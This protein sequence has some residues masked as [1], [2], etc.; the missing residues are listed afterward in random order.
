MTS[1][2]IP[3][4]AVLLLACGPDGVGTDESAEDEVGEDTDTGDDEG[5]EPLYLLTEG[6]GAVWVVDV[7]QPGM[8]EAAKIVPE[9]EEV[10]ATV[11]ASPLARWAAI[12]TGSA[13]ND[14][15]SV[16]V[17]DFVGAPLAPA[18][19]IAMDFP[20]A[21]AQAWFAGDESGLAIETRDL[22][23]DSHHLVYVPLDEQ[24]AGAP[25]EAPSLPGY[26][27]DGGFAGSSH[28]V[29][30]ISDAGT[31]EMFVVAIVDGQPEAA[32][33][34]P[35]F[36]GTRE[37]SKW[38]AADDALFYD[39]IDPEGG[40]DELHRVDL[41]AW[42]EH[43]VQT[44]GPFVGTWWIS[45]DG[46]RLVLRTEDGMQ[47]AEV[48]ES[49][50][51]LESL[52]G[53][54]DFLA[55]SDDGRFG[56]FR[57]AEVSSES[58]EL[59]VFDFESADPL[60]PHP[61]GTTRSSV[62]D[63]A[64]GGDW[65]AWTTD[66]CTAAGVD[67]SGAL[68][69]AVELASGFELQSFT[70]APN[71]ARFYERRVVGG[72]YGPDDQVPTELSVRDLGSASPGPALPLEHPLAEGTKV[73]EIVASPTDTRHFYE[74]VDESYVNGVLWE[75]DPES[76]VRTSIGELNGQYIDSLWAPG[77]AATRP[78]RLQL[79]LGCSN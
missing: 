69:E 41:S 42:P 28:L 40:T 27:Y 23:N 3:V 31:M 12:I 71:T 77:I 68:D 24:G 14:S 35:E 6:R 25:I 2:L 48:D 67:L 32:V 43:D 19:E 13:G 22:P 74:V 49:I 26:P 64:F 11:V 60:V 8:V 16:W 18:V 9:S 70:I 20:V 66:N 37:T 63:I 53:A 58:H 38:Q 50:G 75:H 15:S 59:L 4:F 21:S 47:V 10:F 45:E 46:S 61:L 62:Y 44:I 36:D 65:V 55:L 79:G 33:R 34:M 51:A 52:P 29:L 30:R 76:G 56:L 73:A 17:H 72:P 57:G 5:G 1:R 39:T 78:L 54:T 7:T